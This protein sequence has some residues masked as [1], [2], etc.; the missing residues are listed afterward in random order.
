MRRGLTRVDQHQLDIILGLDPKLIL[1]CDGNPV[2]RPG[3]NAVHANPAA[4]DQI[5]VPVRLGI[6]RDRFAA[7]TV[8][9]RIRASALMVSVPSSGSPLASNWK[10][11]RANPSGKASP[12]SSA[13]A[14]AGRSRSRSGTRS[15]ARPQDYIRRADA[16]PG[17]HHL[18]IAGA[19]AAL[20]AHRILVR[21]RA[22]ADVGHDLHVAVRM[23]RKTTLRGDLVVVPDADPAPA[24]AAGIVIA[25]EGEMVAG[26]EPAVVGMA[27]AGEGRI[28]IMRDR[29]SPGETSQVSSAVTGA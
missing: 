9:P 13:G 8:A 23:R 27:E 11:L 21:D 14:A 22:G 25:G 2:A 3:F 6:D 1:A 16:G 5:K 10:R 15:S 12:P 26:I 24:H 28:S 7:P 4:R 19:G 20:V 29:W 18:H 17:A